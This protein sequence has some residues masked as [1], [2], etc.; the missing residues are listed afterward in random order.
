MARIGILE[1]GRT[2]VRFGLPLAQ[3]GGYVTGFMQ[4]EYSLSGNGWNC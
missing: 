1:G 3:P 4:F 2:N